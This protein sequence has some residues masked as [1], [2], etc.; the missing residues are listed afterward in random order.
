[1]IFKTPLN[2][3]LDGAPNSYAPPISETNLNPQPGFRPIETSLKNATNEKDPAPVFHK[4]GI[5]NTFIWTGVRSKVPSGPS[6]GTID[7]RKFL[8]DHRGQFPMKLLNGAYA[9]YYAPQTAMATA[10][11][12]AVNP[13][14]VPY[15]V[16]GTS[17]KDQ[18]RVRLGDFG[19]AIRIYSGA[20]SGFIY[21]D[22]GG[23]KST[24]VGE[25]S[26]KLIRNLFGGPATSEDICYIVFPGTSPGPVARPDLISGQLKQL[27][28]DLALFD[29]ADALIDR[30][31]NPQLGEPLFA[32]RRFIPPGLRTG[33]LEAAL[34]QENDVFRANIVAALH[35][36]GDL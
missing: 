17:L 23:K 26:R 12:Q 32:G 30:L 35:K 25:S 20:S 3:D 5:G 36:W 10:D 7:Q 31:A 24:S 34:S 1:L 15:A 9:G 6:D 18:G 16:L 22:A 27:L 21:A 2:E 14:E 28:H 13:L 8:R 19:L 11:G 4:D 29:N 33:N